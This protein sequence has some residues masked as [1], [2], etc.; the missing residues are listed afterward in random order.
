MSPVGVTF[1]SF[2]VIFSQDAWGVVHVEAN[3]LQDVGYIEGRADA[4]LALV[5][6]S[7]LQG[8][9]GVRRFWADLEEYV[10]G[11][12]AAAATRRSRT[13]ATPGIVPRLGL[14]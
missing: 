14:S 2:L 9:A 5:L 4:G 12:S 11:R 13:T 7:R 3:D 8:G 6:L 1:Q 10:T